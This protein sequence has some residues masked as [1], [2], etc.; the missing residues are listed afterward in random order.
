MPLCVLM[1]CSIMYMLFFFFFKQKTEYEMRISDW[2][3]DVCSSDLGCI[4]RGDILAGRKARRSI[5]G[6]AVVIPQHIEAAKLQMPGKA[7]RLVIDAFHQAAVAGDHPGVVIDEIAAEGGIQI[8]FRNRHA[9]GR[10]TALPQRSSEKRRVGQ[11]GVRT[12][13]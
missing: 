6:D 3:S 13:R 9:N 1:I 10:G 4:A 12:C 8:P 2:S 5:D 7:D 11:E